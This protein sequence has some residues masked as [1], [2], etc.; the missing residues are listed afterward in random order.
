MTIANSLQNTDT[1]MKLFIGDYCL[2]DE[3]TDSIATVLYHNIKLQKLDIR[4]SDFGKLCIGAAK[5]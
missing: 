5:M 3:A 1:L 2:S 4:L